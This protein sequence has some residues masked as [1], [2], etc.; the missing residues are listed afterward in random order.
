MIFLFRKLRNTM[1]KQNK[2]TTYLLYAL[3]EIILVVVGI[4]IA[5]NI[6]AKMESDK[7][8]KQKQSY[9]RSLINEFEFNQNR[10]IRMVRINNRNQ[11]HARQLTKLMGMNSSSVDKDL[12]DSLMIGTVATETQLSPSTGVLEEIIS[13]GKLDMF[14]SDSLRM[15]LAAWKGYFQRVLFQEEEH[16][17]WRIRMM[18]FMVENSNIT[19]RSI[20]MGDNYFELSPSPLKGNDY[21][22]LSSLEYS[23]FIAMFV[24]TSKYLD[25]G[26]YGRF[27]KQNERIIELLN[28]ELN[29]K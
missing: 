12:L 10:L 28:R 18:N 19:N 15:E 23:N 16:G 9:V 24:I 22:V 14:K 4:L 29:I 26:Y 6:D 2:V 25:V 13:S 21:K 7:K 20:K 8:L 3:G 1:I 5:V 27:K 17:Q 11:A